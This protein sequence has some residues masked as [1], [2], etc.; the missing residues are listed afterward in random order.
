MR[1]NYLIS[2]TGVYGQDYRVFF[3]NNQPVA[4]N[5]DGA[6]GVAF[7]PQGAQ[8]VT[9][10]VLP[11]GNTFFEPDKFVTV[12]LVDGGDYLLG[13]TL[14]ISAK[15]VNDDVPTI[16]VFN[17]SGNFNV[18]GNWDNNIAPPN[19]ILN[20]GDEIIIDPASGECILNVPLTIMKG[21]KIT[22]APGKKLI[23]GN[24]VIIKEN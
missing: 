10:K 8:A 15:I 12:N 17:G 7:I 23:L 20:K 9:I 6:R 2:G 24:N 14:S 18:N 19:N 16:F 11:L 1:I 21:A 4:A 3:E 22:V 13:N 5:F